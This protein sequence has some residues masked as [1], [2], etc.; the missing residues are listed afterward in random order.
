LKTTVKI[1]GTEELEA[2]IVQLNNGMT[3]K[4]ISHRILPLAKEV[5]DHIRDGTPRGPTGNLK[6]SIIAKE[7]TPRESVGT[8]IVAV[9]RK[10]APH[11]HLLEFGTVRMSPHPFFRPGWD[12]VKDHVSREFKEVLKGQVED[13]AK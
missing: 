5:A 6:R 8:V 13:S 9:D 3:G 1:E 4:K 11:A 12:S 2:K 7:L 10:I